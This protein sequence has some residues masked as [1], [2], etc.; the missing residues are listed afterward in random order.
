M[1]A[2]QDAWTNAMIMCLSGGWQAAMP[3]APGCYVTATAQG[4]P[5]GHIH[6]YLDPVT[7]TPT[8][9]KPWEGF[10]WSAPLPTPPPVSEELL[11]SKQE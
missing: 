4:T 9:T 11:R 1:T 6:V 10:W 7:N 8:S 3:T 5:A 2:T